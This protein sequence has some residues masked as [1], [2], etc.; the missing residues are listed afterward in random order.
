MWVVVVWGLSWSLC[1]GGEGVV[2]GCYVLR[3]WCGGV[4]CYGD[5]VRMVRVVYHSLTNQ[6]LEKSDQ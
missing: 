3:G 4:T 1:W 6:K 5:V 2:W